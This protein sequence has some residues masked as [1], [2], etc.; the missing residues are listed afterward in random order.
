MLT[1]LLHWT[2]TCSFRFK[3]LGF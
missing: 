3:K 1:L 2:F